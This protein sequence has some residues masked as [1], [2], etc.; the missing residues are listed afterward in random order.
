MLLVL[1]ND[2]KCMVD[3]SLPPGTPRVCTSPVKKTQSHLRLGH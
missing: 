1:I 2:D 3:F